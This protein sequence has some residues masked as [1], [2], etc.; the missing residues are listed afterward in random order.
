MEQPA[1]G[2]SA[3]IYGLLAVCMIWAARNELNV[4]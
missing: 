2:A 4:S 1:A 3:V